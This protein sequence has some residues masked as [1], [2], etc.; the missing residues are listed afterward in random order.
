MTLV[1]DGGGSSDTL[2]VD[3]DT[4]KATAPTFRQVGQQVDT[5][6]QTLMSSV[7]TASGDMFLLLEFAKMASMLEQLQERIGEAMQCAAGGL[8][9]IGTS[10]EIAS[11]LYIDN[12]DALGATF[13]QL[14]DDKNPWKSPTVL[15]PILPV[16]PFPVPT[17]WP[18]PQPWQQ[19]QPQPQ[20]GPIIP[21]P[22]DGILPFE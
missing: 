6:L 14:E 21:L 9:R 7:Q 20:P 4:L 15:D 11:G 8:K 19:P 16:V 10:L 5:T 1:P 3:T 17:P 12:E 2:S 22:G 18:Q 13:T